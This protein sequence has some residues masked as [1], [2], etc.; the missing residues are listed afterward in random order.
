MSLAQ[1]GKKVPKHVGRKISKAKEG[2]KVSSEHDNSPIPVLHIPTNEVYR[3][4]TQAAAFFKLRRGTLSKRISSG[5]ETD[6]KF[7]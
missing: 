2:K 3:S 6:F 7:L 5:E 4:I 1:L